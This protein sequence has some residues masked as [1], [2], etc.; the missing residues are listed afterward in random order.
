MLVNLDQVFEIM[1]LDKF[2]ARF[3]EIYYRYRLDEVLDWTSFEVLDYPGLYEELYDLWHVEMP[4][5][6]MKGRDG[7]P[8]NWVTEKLFEQFG[9]NQ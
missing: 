1:G 6:I 7:D 9:V 5:G 8:V 3:I 4:Y 2:N